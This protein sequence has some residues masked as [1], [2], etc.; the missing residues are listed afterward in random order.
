MR[1]IVAKVVGVTFDGRQDILIRMTGREPCRLIPDPS[2]PYDANA[3]GVHVAMAD[4][5]I[6]HI[7]FLARELAKQIAPLL[8][9]EAVMARIL[10]VTGG[11]EVNDGEIAAYGLRIA[12]DAPEDEPIRP[13]GG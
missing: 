4:G 5:E 8:D 10:E 7:G 3:I 6:A 2:N 1:T 11:F 13:D 12:I 9:G